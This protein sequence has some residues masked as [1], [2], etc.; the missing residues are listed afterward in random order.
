MS[1][2]QY[3]NIIMVFCNF[4]GNLIAWFSN[5]N[6]LGDTV[7]L[8]PKVGCILSQIST[9]NISLLFQLLLALGDAIKSQV[10]CAPHYPLL[11]FF[12]LVQYREPQVRESRWKG[13]PRTGGGQHLTVTPE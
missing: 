5:V 8:C 10:L 3:E 12:P 9:G 2:A 11:P 7:S 13:D 1:A 4:L 6:F